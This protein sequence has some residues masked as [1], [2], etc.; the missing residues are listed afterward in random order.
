MQ[1]SDPIAFESRK[2]FEV[3]R[4][5]IAQD[6]ELLVMIH[7]LWV[8]RHYLLGSK[9]IV[10]TDN[11]SISRFL[12]QPKLILKQAR[13]QEF[14]AEFDFHFK[15]RLGHLNQAADAMSHKAEL[16]S[17]RLLSNMLAS[18]VNTLI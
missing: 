9:F 8:W 3:K 6:K 15:H 4:W 12:T 5:Y 2:F 17:L 1:E 16:A 18:V 7:C 13:W 14:V 10:K 11:N